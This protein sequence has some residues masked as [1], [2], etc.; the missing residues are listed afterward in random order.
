MAMGLFQEADQ[1]ERRRTVGQLY[2]GRVP[3]GEIAETLGCSKQT[4]TRDVKWLKRLWVE[5]HV[6]F[7]FEITTVNGAYFICGRHLLCHYDRSLT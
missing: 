4:V 5:E 2:I 3:K 6:S 7:H 1:E